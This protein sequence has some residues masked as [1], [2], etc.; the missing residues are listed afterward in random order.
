[1]G[2]ELE[3]VGSE[4]IRAETPSVVAEILS[5]DSLWALDIGNGKFPYLEQLRVFSSSFN[6]WSLNVDFVEPRANL[7]KYKGVL[8][9]SLH[10]VD[11]AIAKGL[12]AFVNQGGV[13][14]LSARSGFKNEDNLATQLPPGPL[15][16]LAR[17]RVK[18]FT[19]LQP[20]SEQRWLDFPVSPAA[21]KPSP[22]NV[23]RSASS[24]WQGEYT[25]KGWVDILESDGAR[26][27]FLYQKDY[28]AGQPAVTIADYGKGKVIYVGT[29]LEPR[30]YVDLAR[31]ACEWAKVEVGVEMP[32]GMDFAL[33]QKDRG[34]FRFMLNFSV[35]PKTIKLSGQHRDLISA[36]TFTGEV[37]VPPLELRVLVPNTPG[38][39]GPAKP[40][41]KT[42]RNNPD[43]G[44][45]RT[46]IR[47]YS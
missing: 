4:F 6:R 27:L 17:V 2:A 19:L 10:V 7:D 23:V 25:A 8:A 41:Y 31:R 38:G 47:T 20:S 45:L 33:R 35:S 29:L 18:S 12:E 21:Y 30:F 9:P 36:M 5:Y 26:P 32:E 43:D 1:M 28:Y 44:Q 40:C 42:Y 24:E 22:D 13:L 37:T 14:I 16:R 46:F 15:E 3:K 11:T 39:A 34:S